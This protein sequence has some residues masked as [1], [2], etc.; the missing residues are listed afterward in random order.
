V[1]D[2]R[3][4]GRWIADH[5]DGPG[6]DRYGDTAIVFSKDGQLTYE[7]DIGAGRRRI[8]NLVYRISSPG[9]IVTDQP[10]APGE[11]LTGYEID[12]MNRLTLDFQGQRSRYFPAD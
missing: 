5:E 3:L 12:D 9:L 1:F 8:A 2:E 11:Q 6:R 7:W 10:S 4:I